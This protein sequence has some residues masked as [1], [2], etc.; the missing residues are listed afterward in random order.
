[1]NNEEL[2]K[3]KEKALENHVPFIMDDTLEY[4]YE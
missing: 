2:Q 1:M 3:I 4:I